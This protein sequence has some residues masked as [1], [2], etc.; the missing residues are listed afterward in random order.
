MTECTSHTAFS[1]SLSGVNLK[2]TSNLA[3]K[4]GYCRRID[5]LRRNLG[6]AERPGCSRPVGRG[7]RVQN[8]LH[9]QVVVAR[10]ACIWFAGCGYRTAYP[11][12]G[13]ASLDPKSL[14]ELR[15]KAP[16]ALFRA[17]DNLLL[18]CMNSCSLQDTHGV[19]SICRY[20]VYGPIYACLKSR[21]LATQSEFRVPPIVYPKIH[22]SV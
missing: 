17:F 9:E 10:H 21:K 1:L 22:Q 18:P 15:H 14:D 3:R 19:R 4:S 12:Y 16:S 13:Y 8:V 5:A 2:H 6:P 20:P 11:L 7:V